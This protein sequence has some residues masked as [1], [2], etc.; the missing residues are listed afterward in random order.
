MEKKSFL[1]QAVRGIIATTRINRERDAEEEIGS[2][3]ISRSIPFDKDAVSFTGGILFLTEEP[4]RAYSI[5]ISLTL[6]EPI[7]LFP[8]LSLVDLEKVVEKVR[9]KKVTCNVRKSSQLCE[10]ISKELNY[11]LEGKSTHDLHEAV[12]N[13]QGIGG[14]FGF[15]PL[16]TGCENYGKVLTNRSLRKTCLEYAAFLKND[17]GIP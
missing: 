14:K 16:P 13:V 9:I 15:S 1:A 17:I 8:L 11:L 3:L 10:E 4:L 7:R 6:S 2:I 5:L 12:L